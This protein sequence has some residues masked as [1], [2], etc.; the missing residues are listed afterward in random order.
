MNLSLSDHLSE[1]KSRIA[2]YVA[3]LLI[4]VGLSYAYSFEIYN[5]LTRPLADIH[6]IHPR[7]LIF[8]GLTEA[9]FMHIK[10]AVFCGFIISFPM[11]ALQI[12]R[13]LKPGLYAA[14]RKIL[15]PFLLLSPILFTL[16]AAM[17][18][19]YVMPL[20]W[21]FFLSFEQ[22]GGE[23]K[24]PILLE[25]RVSE[26]LSL[27]M[28]LIIGFGL[29]FQLPLVLILLGYLGLVTGEFLATKRRHFIVLIFIIAAIL[30]PPDVISQIAL[31]IPLMILYE[32]SVIACKRI[33]KKR[34]V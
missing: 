11:L 21:E 2:K 31:A 33:D 10:L 22:L 7:K 8:T 19:F 3:F 12:Y 1:L 20:A 23:N 26:Y 29:A 32:V 14:E 25:A 15:L 30:T 4:C 6:N 5:L 17:V 24:L 13:F 9:F 16:G 27:V 28:S 18:Y 34:S